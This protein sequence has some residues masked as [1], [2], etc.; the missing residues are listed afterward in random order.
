[1]PDERLQRRGIRMVVLGLLVQIACSFHWSPGTFVLSSVLG[2][3]LV[4][5]GAFSCWRAWRHGE[6]DP[7]R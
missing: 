6:G 4:G 3:P 1:M 7:E 2:A 5:L